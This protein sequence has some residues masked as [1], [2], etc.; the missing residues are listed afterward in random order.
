MAAFQESI[1]GKT[2]NRGG[3]RREGEEEE[4]VKRGMQK[5]KEGEWRCFGCLGASRRRAGLPGR[6]V[7][8]D[9]DDA[10]GA[11]TFLPS[12]SCV[13]CVRTLS[14]LEGSANVMKPNP[15]QQKGKQGAVLDGCVCYLP[16]VCPLTARD[17]NGAQ[18]EVAP[19]GGGAA[20]A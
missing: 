18:G 13:A 1:R 6:D 8:N 12:S 15:L 7:G 20:G 16:R 9:E 14:T 10:V 11:L 2:R 3:S 17:E 5:K 19:R 4:K